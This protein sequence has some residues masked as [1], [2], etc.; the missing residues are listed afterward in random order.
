MAVPSRWRGDHP[1]T[2][3]HTASRGGAHMAGTTI[4]GSRTTGI[5]LSDTAS[6]AVLVTGTIDVA[7][8]GAF[9]A[10]AASAWSVTNQGSIHS[11][12]GTAIAIVSGTTLTNAKS[13]IIGGYNGIYVGNAR[14]TVTNLGDIAASGANGFG[15]QLSRGGSV[16]NQS[17]GTIS[18]HRAVP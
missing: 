13:G 12:N 16:I 17:G 7:S 8:G 2:A 5:A 10:S 15:I 14:G 9:G 4:S 1:S 18:G 11:G 3:G 6:N